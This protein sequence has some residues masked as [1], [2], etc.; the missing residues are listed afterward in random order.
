MNRSR[1]SH[2]PRVFTDFIS[3]DVVPSDDSDS[4][5][6]E[7]DRPPTPTIYIPSPNQTRA[8]SVSPSS[9]ASKMCSSSTAKPMRPLTAYHI[10][11]QLEREY[12]IQNLP[13]SVADTSALENKTCRQDV[14]R[15]YRQT[16]LLPD[17]YAGPGKRQKRKHRKS[18]GKIGFL[19]LSRVISKRWANLD[20]TD[21]ETKV[22]VHKIAARELD[23][24]KREMCVW[25]KLNGVFAPD[26]LTEAPSPP[27]RSARIA[28]KRAASQRKKLSIS[29]KP[30]KA[31]SEDVMAAVTLNPMP[32]SAGA[33]RPEHVNSNAVFRPEPVNS[34]A[35]FRPEPVFSGLSSVVSDQSLTQRSNYERRTFV[36]AEECSRQ[37]TETIDY[38]ICSDNNPFAP[39]LQ[40]ETIDLCDPLFELDSFSANETEQRCVSPLSYDASVDVD[41]NQVFKDDDVGLLSA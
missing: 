22:F 21:L 35:V 17:W 24:Y 41:M 31:T 8:L 27:R 40:L 1:R 19:E 38:S 23:E 20:V 9:S 6:D 36:T 7:P 28:P 2:K 11:F 30:M 10:Y 29:P 25:K 16:K 15:R 5:S 4:E 32:S 26:S 3:T 13:G 37:R 39:A 33:F 12:V 34:S 18:H 14:P